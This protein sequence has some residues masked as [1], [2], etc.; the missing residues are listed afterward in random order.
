MSN[1]L[2][3]FMSAQ[4]EEDERIARAAP[5]GP[6]IGT[7]AEDIGAWSVY[8]QEWLI[9]SATVYTHDERMGGKRGPGYI[10]A[11]ATTAHI[12]RHDPSRAA[13][14]LA[15]K[16]QNLAE[17][18]AAEVKMDQAARDRDTARYNTVRAEWTVLRRV[19]RRDAFA[20]ADRPGYREEWRPDRSP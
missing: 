5:P 11:S 14:E 1:D 12:A 20:Y 9:A 6:W 13:R 19:V 4:L 7:D 2:V 17:L 15:A 18:A 10:D 16:R 3:D 8:D